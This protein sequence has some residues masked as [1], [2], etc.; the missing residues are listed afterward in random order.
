MSAAAIQRV[1]VVGGGISGL[2]AAYRLRE[3]ARERRLPV[4]VTLFERAARAGGCVETV[5]RDGFTMETGAETLLAEKPAIA[6]LLRRLGLEGELV[7]TRPEFKGSRVLRR[8]RLVPL[9]PGVQLFAPSSPVALATSGLFSLRGLVR[10]AFEPFVPVRRDAEDESLAAF[11]TRRLGREVLERL[12]Q[13]LI[14]GIYSSDPERLSM[15][16]TLPRFLEMERGSGSLVRALAGSGGARRTAALM[17]LRGGLGALVER[18]VRE[19]AG[20]VKVDCGVLALQRHCRSGGERSWSLAL[21]DGSTAAFD[22]VVCA[23]PLHESA[24]LLRTVQPELSE[25]LGTIVYN[26]IATV[27]LAFDE[28]AAPALPRSYGV[29]VPFAE[30]RR[31]TALTIVSQ[32]YPGRAPAGT[33]LLRAFIG[34]ALQAHLLDADDEGLVQIARDEVRALLGVTAA[35]RVTLVR[36][37]THRL[38]EYALGHLERVARIER[39]T[40]ALPNFALAGAALHGVGVPDCVHSGERAA[41]ETLDALFREAPVAERPAAGGVI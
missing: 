40:A 36:R 2:A 19:L 11:V 15:Q 29:V 24:R 3:L 35:P 33:V 37:W 38:P 32:K 13:P 18:L 22:A 8:G 16:A 39:E 31:I 26:S 6:D 21:S 12:A 9:P 5:T 28:G 14:G 34:G 41:E 4:E 17:G 10:M 1:A 25:L 20:A 27:N 7:P 23:A 30:G